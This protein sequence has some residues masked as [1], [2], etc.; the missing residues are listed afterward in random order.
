MIQRATDPNAS[1]LSYR[2]GQNEGKGFQN[3]SQRAQAS[4]A[5]PFP[6]R[7][8]VRPDP[9]HDGSKGPGNESGS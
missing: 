1:R 2:P 5:W 7:Y 9:L 8:A 6:S 4:H 3:Q